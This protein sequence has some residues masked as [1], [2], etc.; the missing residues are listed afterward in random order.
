MDGT[1]ST[2][3]SKHKKLL[4]ISAAVIVVAGAAA[5][6]AIVVFSGKSAQQQNQT[7]YKETTV[8]RG[9]ITVGITETGTAALETTSITYDF[10]ADVETINVK[11][12]QRVNKGDVLAT[13][14]TD[15][16]QTELVKAE[17]ELQ[18]N[19]LALSQAQ[20][21]QK[22]QKV[23]SEYTYKSNQALETAAPQQY[24]ATVDS[25]NSEL[26]TVK[27][28]MSNAQS[29]ISEYN[30]YFDDLSTTYDLTALHDKV[31]TTQKA[32][33]DAKAAYDLDTSNEDKKAA[34]EAAK[35][36]HDE[37]VKAYTNAYNL[38]TASYN[39]IATKLEEA[40]NQYDTAKLK[41]EKL[42][43]SITLDTLT[44]ESKKEQS[45]TTSENAKLLYEIDT[46]KTNNEIAT[47]KLTIKTLE[48]QI[49][50]IKKKLENTTV[51]SPCSGLVMSVGYAPGDTIT[52]NNALFTISNSENVYATVSVAQEDIN[53]IAIGDSAQ[54]S[55]DAFEGTTFEGTVDSVATSP[56][57]TASSTVSY[58]VTVKLSG[59][60]AKIYEGM[61]GDVT[62]ISKQKKN[63]LYIP[64]RAIYIENDKQY[65]KTKDSSGNIQ[66]I[67]VTTGFSDGTNAEITS[68]LSE[69]DVVLI[70][71][72]VTAK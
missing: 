11:A 34:Y 67:E 61:T 65:V 66:A 44:A 16:L 6:T 57:R 46:A 4:I 39:D 59:D 64:N 7:Q 68:G 1:K 70:E 41:Y 58:T 13:L 30:D 42:I 37:A 2:F 60:T 51:T 10:T 38:Y 53:S 25:L 19:K 47:Q 5:V 20:V 29:K 27:E 49:E 63:V 32:E 54:V 14:T 69:G 9:D 35:A 22:V 52:K 8:T 36:A 28:T 55:L 43:A 40:Q 3:F 12:G 56:A 31:V 72:K 48:L 45:L 26:A 50:E 23:A 71:G 24:T 15:S 17:L 62:F 18:K 21:D 33:T